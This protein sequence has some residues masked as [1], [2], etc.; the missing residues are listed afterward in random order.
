MNKENPTDPLPTL[1]EVAEQLAAID[2]SYLIVNTRTKETIDLYTDYRA[3]IKQASK[4]RRAGA[5][6]AVFKELKS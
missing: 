4:Y 6:V 1:Q 2:T 3:A 5:T